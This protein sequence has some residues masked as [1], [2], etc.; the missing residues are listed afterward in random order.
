M[1]AKC[2]KRTFGY[3][4]DD[5]VGGDQQPRRNSNAERLCCSNVDGC[6]EFGRGLYWEIGG[7]VAA[8]NAVNIGG[9]T[10]VLVED[11]VIPRQ[12]ADHIKNFQLCR[13]AAVMCTNLSL[14]RSL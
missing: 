13:K 12:N 3:S 8:Q 9:R 4:L 10:A 2:Q 11:I 1:S 7:L 14:A 5:L 6:S